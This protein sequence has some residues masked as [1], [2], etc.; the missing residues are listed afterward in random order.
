[1]KSIIVL[2]TMSL[3][4]FTGAAQPDFSQVAKTKIAAL[5]LMVGTWQGKAYASTPTGRD[6][7]N[8]VENIQYKLDSTILFI[9]GKGT[10]VMEDGSEM[11]VHHA[12]GILSFHP[13][14][15]QY[16]MSSFISKGMSTVAQVQ[17]DD[18]QHFTW[19]FESGPTTIRYSIAI[20]DH[21]WTEIGKR[22][23]DGK[24]WIQ[25]FEMKL[26]KVN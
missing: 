23:N 25:F 18:A 7:S 17:I 15:Q 12:L 14:K 19:W 20:V 10:K 3:L 8:V 13:F 5:D 24:N 1:M 2:F 21:T 22:S 11:V 6:S 4:T 26:D 9:E 16:Q